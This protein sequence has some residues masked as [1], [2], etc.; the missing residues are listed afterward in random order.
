MF[1]GL[2]EKI[3]KI[4]FKERYSSETYINYLRSQG[5]EI[6]EGTRIFAS[7]N[8]VCIDE[9]R[10]WMIKIGNNVQ[11]TRG[12]IMLTHDYAWS[13]I[14]GVYGEICGSCGKI[15]IGNNV[16]IGM[17]SI[18]LKGV[19]VGNNVIIGAGSIVS[20]DVPDNS[21]VAGNPAKKIM[22]IDEYYKKRKLAQYAEAKEL[23]Q[24]YYQTYGNK[25]SG[26]IMDEFFWLYTN[27]VENIDESYD[28]KMH[29]IGNYKDS[30]DALEKNKP[31]F[32]S[33]EEFIDNVLKEG[34]ENEDV[35]KE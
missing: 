26:K 23:V 13:V 30:V 8:D 27:T 28:R 33:E 32:I 21:V 10:P 7:P 14:K 29:L 15:V 34:G 35:S 11:I 2:R 20:K 22:T 12:V 19:K 17:N 16:F 5:M 4:V 3:K 31:K 18:I 25:P 24:E 1:S 6:G 9:S